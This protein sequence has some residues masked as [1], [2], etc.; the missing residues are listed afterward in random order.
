MFR[1]CRKIQR[2]IYPHHPAAGQDH[3]L[4]PGKPVG[5]TGADSVEVDIT[6]QRPGSMHMQIAEVRKALGG[7]LRGQG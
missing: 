5:V 7:F 1:H 2:P 6:V 4:T 3:R